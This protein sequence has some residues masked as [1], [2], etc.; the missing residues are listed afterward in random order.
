M[1]VMHAGGVLFSKKALGRGRSNFPPYHFK[2][3]VFRV[4]NNIKCFIVPHLKTNGK[5][6][7]RV[8]LI[9]P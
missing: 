2:Y 6:G 3:F 4:T 8:V 5:T 9:S 1:L 7:D